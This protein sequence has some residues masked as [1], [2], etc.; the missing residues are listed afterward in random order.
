M[1]I[2]QAVEVPVITIKEG[3]WEIDL[4]KDDVQELYTDVCFLR[5]AVLS[6]INPEVCNKSDI[7]YSSS[8][9]KELLK[10]YFL[11]ERQLNYSNEFLQSVFK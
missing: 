8:Q 9:Y 10:E 1:E 2:T 4:T 3:I 5:N 11:R 7:P 6:L